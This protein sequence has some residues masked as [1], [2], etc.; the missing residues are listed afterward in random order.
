VDAVGEGRW[1]F[2]GSEALEVAGPFGLA[3]RVVPRNPL[4]AAPT[5]LGLVAVAAP[6]TVTSEQHTSF[7]D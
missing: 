2:R 1:V 3:V 7:G 5:E 4:M 6:S